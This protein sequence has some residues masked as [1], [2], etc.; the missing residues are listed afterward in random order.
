MENQELK[1]REQLH[2]FILDGINGNDAFKYAMYG[3]YVSAF[4]KVCDFSELAENIAGELMTASKEQRERFFSLTDDL[5]PVS[6]VNSYDMGVQICSECGKLI[7][8]GYYIAGEYAC[9]HECGVK[10]YMG[11]FGLNEE[12]AAEAFGEDLAA[13]GNECLPDVYYTEW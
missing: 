9:S 4:G 12:E 6:P 1:I 13:N 7:C 5:N 11:S 2:N 8:E 3:F 10:N